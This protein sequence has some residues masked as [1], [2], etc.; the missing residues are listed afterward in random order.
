MFNDADNEML[1]KPVTEEEL[2]G[3]L[4]SFKKNKSP[5]PDGWTIE[6]LTHFY[7]LIKHDLLRMVEATRMSGH[8]HHITSST[9]IALIPK[10]IDPESFNDFRPISL[11]N[12]SFKIITKIIAER[13]KGN[14][15]TF[16]TRDQYAFL[17]GRNILDVIANT[18][19]CLSTMYAKN[20]PAAIMKIDLRKAFDC[21]DWGFMEW[22]LAKIFS[23][24]KK[25][26][27]G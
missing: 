27:D 20:L 9:L 12:I 21:L 25:T 10:K 16:L 24:Y 13:L 18:Q 2:L 22:L 5:G 8:I 11:C 6:F 19:K 1:Y 3:V 4:K 17:H 26:F 14:L 15:A 23:Q 7:E